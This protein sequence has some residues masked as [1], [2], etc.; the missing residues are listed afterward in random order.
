MNNLGACPPVAANAAAQTFAASL[1]GLVSN[2][3]Y[4]YRIVFYNSSNGSTQYGA[5]KTFTTLPTMAIFLYPT[6]LNF[7]TILAGTVSTPLT[8]TATNTGPVAMGITGIAL[9]GANPTAFQSSNNCGASLAAGASC[10]ITVKFEPAVAGPFS[11]AVTLTDSAGNS[12]QSISLAGAANGPVVLLSATSLSFPAQGVN[13]GSAPQ[14]VLLTNIGGAPLTVAGIKLT[15]TN[16]AEFRTSNN[17]GTSL[18]AGAECTISVSF[19]PTAKGA[20][21]A[22]LAIT[23]NATG[24][25]QSV[26]LL[27]TGQQEK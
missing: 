8:V 23:D 7:G 16:A 25:P 5:I 1:T 9:G 17:C 19:F 11:A 21:H 6:S 2:T 12:P 4:Y 10:T 14:D 26:A 22:A 20:A 18:A 15:G 13:T 27:G 24:S 3:T